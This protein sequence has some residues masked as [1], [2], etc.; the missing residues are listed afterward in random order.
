MPWYI[1]WA[2]APLNGRLGVFIASP[3]I[4]DVGQKQQLSV[5]ERTGQ[6]G[7]HRTSTV[8]CPVPWPRQPAVGVCSSRLLDPTVTQTV[9]C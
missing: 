3:T 6:S 1:L 7:A 2:P 5:N 4:V 9:R 8:H